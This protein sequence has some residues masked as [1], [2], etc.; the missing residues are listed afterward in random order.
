MRKTVLSVSAAVVFASGW[1]FAA[2]ALASTSTSGNGGVSSTSVS[3]G[4]DTQQGIGSSVLRPGANPDNPYSYAYLPPGMSVPAPGP[5]T[6]W[7]PS[8]TATASGSSPSTS[9][10]TSSTNTPVTSSGSTAPTSGGATTPAPPP[11]TTPPD[12]KDVNSLPDIAIGKPY[13]LGVQWPDALFASEAAHFPNTGQLTDGNFASLSF[14]DPGW[15][16]FLRQGGQSIVVNL[17]STQRVDRVSLDFLQNMGAGINFPDSVT[18]YAS[19]N[20]KT[21]YKLGTAVTTQGGGSY[22]PQTQ[23]YTIETHVHAQYIRAQFTDK[24]FSFADEFSVFGPG[25]NTGQVHSPGLVHPLMGSAMSAMMGNDY[26]YDPTTPGLLTLRQELRTFASPSGPAGP[27]G[28]KPD[29]SLAQ[30]AQLHWALGQ[31]NNPGRTGGPITSLP[32]PGYLT[33]HDEGTDGIKNMELIYTGAPHITDGYGRYTVSDF[34]PTI[35]EE[36]PNGKPLGWMFDGALFG[37]YGTPTTSAAI[38]SWLS[39]LFTP[40]LN[41]SALNQAVGT[42]KQKLNHPNYKE[43]VVITIPGLTADNANF[44]AIDS[45]GQNIDLNPNDVGE[46]QATINKAKVIDWFMNTVLQDWN[47]A[48]FSNLQLAGFYWQP[49]ALNAADPLDTTLIQYTASRVHQDGYKF[50]WIPFYG[51]WGISDWN[52]LGFDDVTSQAGVAFNFGINAKARLNS[53]ADM[54]Q[55][56]H[57][58]LEMEQPFN[59]MSTNTTVAQNALNHFYDYFT[60]GY[61]Y[62]YEVAV[63][64]TWYLNSK[65]LEGPYASTNPF[66][67]AQ[68]DSVVQFVNDAWKSTTFY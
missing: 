52:R 27:A 12:L 47:S 1:L 36:S 53:V 40:N 65:G 38:N 67:H 45:S 62:G 64:K 68:Y 50:F 54:A 13:T 22:T 4:A 19:N 60:G 6:E 66:Y 5:R 17:G 30:L 35:A 37:P 61:V 23:P 34:L 31:A 14:S 55:F 10:S 43:K 57:T 28:P 3:N 58:G 59:T 42:L 9:T 49:E 25:T 46:V 26:L 20:G 11:A 63:E 24:V 41:L 29:N 8:P 2:T 56:Y 16:G 32:N 44:G 48:G 33:S 18:Y 39:D 21:W 15:V 7:P 51:A